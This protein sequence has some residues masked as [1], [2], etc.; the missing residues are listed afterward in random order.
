M[1]RKDYVKLAEAFEL[2]TKHSAT[3]DANRDYRAGVIMA[4]RQ[5]AYKLAQDNPRFDRARFMR[6]CGFENEE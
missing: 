4:A 1:T 3:Y 5:V 2:I 6:A